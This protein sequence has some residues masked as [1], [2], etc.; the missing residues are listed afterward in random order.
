MRMSEDVSLSFCKMYP[1]KTIKELLATPKLVTLL[2]VGVFVDLLEWING[3]IQFVN[4]TVSWGMSLDFTFVMYVT[5]LPSTSHQSMEF[6]VLF[7]WLFNLHH[8]LINLI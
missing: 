1:K 6:G 7:R 5:V 4:A 2:Y 8:A 3:F